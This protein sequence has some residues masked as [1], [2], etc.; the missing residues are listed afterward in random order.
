MNIMRAY[1]LVCGL[2][3]ME[4][5]S[6]S[7]ARRAGTRHWESPGISHSYSDKCIVAGEVPVKKACLRWA[8]WRTMA[9]TY[10]PMWCFMKGQSKAK[11]KA[12]NT[13]T[14][15]GL[16]LLII[17]SCYSNCIP[18]NTFEYKHPLSFLF[19]G[20]EGFYQF[21]LL[22]L[23]RVTVSLHCSSLCYKCQS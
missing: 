4:S 16:I 22:S 1:C 3:I 5:T 17:D 6:C 9:A 21:V 13:E 11:S 15:K 10:L 19:W 18:I 2:G 20:P 8:S 14:S 23:Q 7:Q 12:K